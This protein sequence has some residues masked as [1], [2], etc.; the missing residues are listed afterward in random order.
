MG[1][2][3]AI[4]TYNG[5]SFISEQMESILFQS[6]PVDEIIIC[7]DISTDSTMLIL[8]KFQMRFPDVVKIHRNKVKLGVIKN[9]EKAI[10]LCNNELILLSDQDDIWYKEKTKTIIEFFNQN[11]FIKA[12]FHNLD[13]QRKEEIL[14]YTNWESIHFSPDHVEQLSLLHRLVL[15]GNFVTGASLAFKKPA[16]A[17]EF[18]IARNLYHDYQLALFFA[19]KNQLGLINKSL[20]IYRLHANQ[21]VGIK[22]SSARKDTYDL[23][24]SNDRL[25]EKMVFLGKAISFWD[26]ELDFVNKEMFINIISPIL[27][28]T[29]KEYLR[30]LSFIERKFT[31][32]SWILKKKYFTT[33]KDF[34]SL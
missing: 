20:G 14:P 21:Q 24:Q 31:V 7:D 34:L 27:L 11:P 5:E 10:N 18:G 15:T 22:S 32:L 2:S 17:I 6:I 12:V 1:V 26:V 23:I 33:Y 25:Q 16:K 13:L 30:K 3:V 19:E 28:Q 8:E 4:C 29:K 9:F